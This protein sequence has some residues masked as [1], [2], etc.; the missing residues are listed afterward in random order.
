MAVGRAEEAL[1]RAEA[2]H[3]A[4]VAELHAARDEAM[5]RAATLDAQLERR[6]IESGGTGA[7]QAFRMLERQLA[8][9]KAHASDMQ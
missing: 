3:T 9:A 1:A 7:K 5:Q 4:E 6:E 2:S 8:D